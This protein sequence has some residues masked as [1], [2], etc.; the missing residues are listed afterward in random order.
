MAQDINYGGSGEDDEFCPLFA[1]LPCEKVSSIEVFG[2]HAIPGKGEKHYP[3]GSVP[4]NATEDYLC[5]TLDHSGG[6]FVLVAR[7]PRGQTLSERRARYPGDETW[8][9]RSPLL[10]SELGANAPTRSRSP[11]ADEF[12]EG[13]P[14][15]IPPAIPPAPNRENITTLKDGVVVAN[16]LP[17]ETR[18]SVIDR[19]REDH[20]MHN[21]LWRILDGERARNQEFLHEAQKAQ[22]RQW[23]QA[24]AL[25]KATQS[26]SAGPGNAVV[27]QFLQTQIQSLRAELEHER[28]EGRNLRKE[29]DELTRKI[30]D[31]ESELRK[32]GIEIER[33]EFEKE[34]KIHEVTQRAHGSTNESS[35]PNPLIASMA[36]LVEAGAQGVGAGVAKALA[37]TLE[38]LFS[39]LSGKL[40]GQSG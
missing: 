27:E 8:I 39:S 16:D 25:L 5:E 22:Q 31:L 36:P 18:Q 34:K 11:F 32:N 37:P 24:L 23:E 40:P 2:V 26:V 15:A 10:L 38:R 12:S 20:R 1:N 19:Q 35:E 28:Q 6:V 4:P 29:R 3:I 13:F 7:S 33:V 30:L 9:A 17:P 14:P 21:D